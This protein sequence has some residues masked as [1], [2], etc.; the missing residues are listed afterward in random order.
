MQS[1]AELFNTI[2]DAIGRLF[3]T[4]IAGWTWGQWFLMIILLSLVSSCCGGCFC[5]RRRRRGRNHNSRR[6]DG[7]ADDNDRYASFDW[8]S[9]WNCWTKRLNRI[10]PTVNEY[11][12][13]MQRS[14]ATTAITIDRW[15]VDRHKNRSIFHIIPS[16]ELACSCR[17]ECIEIKE[18]SWSKIGDTYVPRV[19]LI[20]G[21]A[22]KMLMI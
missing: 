3:T 13:Q 20:R 6:R 22:E 16:H 8:M 10:G 15:A 5:R 7:D 4:P 19:V 14:R 12:C 18:K 9:N 1:P 21:G 11:G 17:F 2:V